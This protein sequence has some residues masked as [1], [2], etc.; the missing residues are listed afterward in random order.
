MVKIFARSKANEDLQ[1]VEVESNWVTRA[2]LQHFEEM[3]K[4]I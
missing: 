1:L 4:Y 2:P 3:A